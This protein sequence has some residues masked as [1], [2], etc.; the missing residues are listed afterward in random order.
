MPC[1]TASTPANL[2]TSP[3]TTR[4]VVA[5]KIVDDERRT[6]K[7]IYVA[8]WDARVFNSNAARRP[9]ESRDS[10]TTALTGAYRSRHKTNLPK[11]GG[12]GAVL[13]FPADKQ[14]PA[15][16]GAAAQMSGSVSYTQF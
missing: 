6:G 2:L 1:T 4:I 3:S 12:L 15:V 9:H 13:F 10:G 16:T 8:A 7:A 11:A 5:A 14:V